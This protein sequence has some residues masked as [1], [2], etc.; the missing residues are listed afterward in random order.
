MMRFAPIAGNPGLAEVIRQAELLLHNF[1]ATPRLPWTYMR[2]HCM[3]KMV[4][5]KKV[6]ENTCE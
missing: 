1:P 4:S 5:E 3:L 6:G 2:C